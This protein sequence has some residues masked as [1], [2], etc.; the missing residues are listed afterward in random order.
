MVIGT[1]TSALMETV[2]RRYFTDAD[3]MW[4][5]HTTITSALF[6]KV[7]QCERTSQALMDTS[8]TEQHGSDFPSTDGYMSVKGGDRVAS[9]S[10]EQHH[11]N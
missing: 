8:I 1:L 6:R 10:T 5:G 2:C 4:V 9:L 7:K 3:A 11:N